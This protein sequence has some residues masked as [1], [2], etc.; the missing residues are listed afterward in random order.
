MVP[1]EILGL[2]E[3]AS[4]PSPSWLLRPTRYEGGAAFR[5]LVDGTPSIVL[6]GQGGRY[7]F[8]VLNA[9]VDGTWLVAKDTIIEVDP[10]RIA[11]PFNG[12]VPLGAIC[13]IDDTPCL[14]AKINY[15]RV[16]LSL[17]TGEPVAENY[18]RFSAFTNWRLSVP[19]IGDDRVVVY[20]SAQT[21]PTQA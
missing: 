17:R 14:L 7:A 3:P 12:E 21:D 18:N 2:V 1:I 19:G 15:A 6:L 16:F 13:I 10:D 8:D 9:P 20:S 5:C 4:A 11:S